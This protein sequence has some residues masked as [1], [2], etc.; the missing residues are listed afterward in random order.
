LS[1]GYTFPRER[2]T[3]RA[4]PVARALDGHWLKAGR[5]DSGC[6]HGRDVTRWGCR[7][8]AEPR[9]RRRAC[10]RHLECSNRGDPLQCAWLWTGLSSANSTKWQSALVSRIR[11]IVRARD[12]AADDAGQ[13]PG[14]GDGDVEAV[15]EKEE[16]QAEPRRLEHSAEH[17]RS[18]PARPPRRCVSARASEATSGASSGRPAPAATSDRSCQAPES[19][20]RLSGSREDRSDVRSQRHD[21]TALGVARGVFVGTSPPKV[22]FGHHLVSARPPRGLST[23]RLLHNFSARAA[24]LSGH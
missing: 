7:H 19:V 18:A 10:A 4:S 15:A 2:R 20:I 6:M 21:D 12:S 3:A 22:V 17:A 16:L 23:L 24:S 13:T 14:P 11:S 5:S 9:E 1:F 8:A